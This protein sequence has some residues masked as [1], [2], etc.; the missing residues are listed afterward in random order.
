MDHSDISIDQESNNSVQINHNGLMVQLVD[1]YKTLGQKPILHGASLD[2]DPGETRVIIGRSG[3]GKSVLIKHICGLFQVD[4]GSVFVDGEEITYYNEKKLLP[5]RQKIGLLFQNSALF[6]SLN[7]LHNVGFTLFEEKKLS[8]SDIRDLVIE[9]LRRVKLGDILEKM[10]S[11]LSGGMKKR[12]GLAR[13]IINR[14]KILLYDE[15]TTGLD[16][17][18]SDAINDLINQLS[19]ELKMTSIVITH[20]MVSAFKIATR[21]SMLFEGKIIFTGTPTEVRETDNEIIQQFIQGKSEGP[22]SNI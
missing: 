13:A 8:E 19:D 15:P 7:V 22:L 16:P 1:L 14:P 17:V 10:P 5:V 12:V 4:K 11:E 20:D 18:T 2:I 3:E 9:N 21:F 6:D